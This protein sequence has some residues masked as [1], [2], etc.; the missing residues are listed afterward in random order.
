[1]KSELKVEWQWK[2][3]RKVHK[4]EWKR[5]GK[6]WNKE[7]KKTDKR[8][9][10]INFLKSSSNLIEGYANFQ[11]LFKSNFYKHWVEKKEKFSHLRKKQF[12]KGT[13]IGFSLHLY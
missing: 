6:E 12:K 5:I 11:C 3:G 8:N 1:M 9:K 2:K 4:E 7:K 13:L 10:N